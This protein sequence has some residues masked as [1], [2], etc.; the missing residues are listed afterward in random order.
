M[1]TAIYIAAPLVTNMT[2]GYM[3]SS[4]RNFSMGNKSNNIVK[5][6]ELHP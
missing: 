4:N 3:E 6:W 5:T 1:M 2:I